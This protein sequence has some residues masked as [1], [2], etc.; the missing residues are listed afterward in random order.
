MKQHSEGQVRFSIKFS[1]NSVEKSE[2]MTENSVGMR[3]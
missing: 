1:G 3:S 2:A